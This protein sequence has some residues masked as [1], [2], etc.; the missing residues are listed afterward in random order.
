[1][2]RLSEIV[3]PCFAEVHRDIKAN[4][5]THYFLKGGRGSTKSSFV[6]IEIIQGIMRYPDANGIALRKIGRDLKETVFMQLLW[7]IDKLGVSR[8]WTIHFSPLRLCYRPTG[9]QILFRGVDD[10]AKS[11]SIKLRSGYFKYI[12]FEEAD[13]F[14]GIEEI[15][16]VTQSLIRGGENQVVLY[17]YNPPKSVN[18]WINA[19]I[20]QRT[21]KKDDY[22]TTYIHHS[23]YLDVPKK[24][25]GDEFIR[26]AEILKQANEDAYRHEYLGEVTGTGGEIFKNVVLREITADEVKALGRIYRGLDF[27]FSTDPCA[28]IACCL[29]NYKLYIFHEFYLTE[30]GFDKM[31]ELISEENKLNDL[32]YADSAEPRS[33]HELAIRGIKISG[34]RKYQGS[35]DHGVSRLSRDL[36]EIVIDPVKCPNAAKE[37]T[38]YEYERDK[39]DIFK[40]MYPDKNNHTI[41]AVRYALSNTEFML[42]PDKKA[43]KKHIDFE[44][45]NER[46]YGDRSPEGIFNN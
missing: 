9:Q 29:H 32:I 20:L 24:W 31:A 27:G 37:F 41:D 44:F 17:T 8:Y 22:K 28:Y 4:G 43:V 45:Q 15:R 19:E 23:S 25:L 1:M 3:S 10:A 7:A 33:I 35:V 12:W 30:L 6:S 46:S 2:V 13:Q 40:A 16:K 38:T 5:H 34:A 26:E 42:K 11:K 18:N 39:D 36:I 14:T 21:T